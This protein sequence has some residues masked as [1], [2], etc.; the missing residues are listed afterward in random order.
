M[1]SCVKSFFGN[2]D[3]GGASLYLFEVFYYFQL[4]NTVVRNSH[5]LKVDNKTNK[6]SKNVK[7]TLNIHLFILFFINFAQGHFLTPMEI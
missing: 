4:T 6:N 7:K 5:I 2:D 3:G 1:F